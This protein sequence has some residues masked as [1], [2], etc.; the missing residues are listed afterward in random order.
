MSSEPPR[1]Y[2]VAELNRKLRLRLERWGEVWVEGEVSDVRRAV[3]GHV[4]FTLEDGQTPAQLRVVMFRS[5]ARAARAR[6]EPGER[7]RVLGT[8][9]L[10]E[11]RGAFQLQVRLALPVGEGDRRAELLRLEKK[12]RAEGL[13]D[14]RR[15][16]P[17]PLYP[18]VVGLVTS[19]AGAAVHD[20]VEVA[21]ARAPVHL[22]LVHA[23][24]Q[25]VDAPRSL[26]DALRKVARVPRLDVVIVTRGGGAA[27]DLGAFNDE[28]VVRALASCP[29]PVV[30]GVGHGVD[31]TLADLVADVRAATP[32]NAAERVVPSRAALLDRLGALHRRLERGGER[33][34]RGGELRLER[35]TQRLPRPERR[36]S[37][38][39]R[40]L[41]GLTKRLVDAERGLRSARTQRLARAR[42]ALRRLEPRQRVAR[43]RARVVEARGRL[44]VAVAGCVAARRRRLDPL[45]EALLRGLRGRLEEGRRR[46]GE[47]AAA[48]QALSPLAVLARG[49][50]IALHE[51]RALTRADD[52]AVGDEVELR[53]HE[54]RLRLRVEE[55]T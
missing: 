21:F 39:R 20:V 2:R 3:S 38:L 41:D 12:L 24:V 10:Y 27:E 6:L 25:G 29:V 49:Y 13:F 4:Y 50:A 47:R 5:D 40:R 22:V 35:L 7:V 42:E 26:V 32:S 45:P 17:L 54:G 31:Q 30:S 14:E 8:F 18:R 33:A 16:R 34:V 28:R 43:D 48:L 15:K 55:G 11:A 9:T 37:E 53:L 44:D 19:R 46:L 23:T 51:G 36:L 52:A 1:I